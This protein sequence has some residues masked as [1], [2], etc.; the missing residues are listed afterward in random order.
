MRGKATNDAAAGGRASGSAVSSSAVDCRCG[1]TLA[2]RHHTGRLHVAAGV[3][4][5]FDP[6]GRHG[7]FLGL[8]CPACGKRRD[9]SLIRSC[10]PAEGL[11]LGRP[12]P[13]E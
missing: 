9:Y 4:C 7:A 5:F 11:P 8:T 3:G 13:N 2:R 1:E 6:N 12:R 10:R